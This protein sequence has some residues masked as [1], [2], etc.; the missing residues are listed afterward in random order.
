M[1]K[2]DKLRQLQRDGVIRETVPSLQ[3]WHYEVVKPESLPEEFKK[4]YET[5]QELRFDWFFMEGI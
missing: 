2:L 4:E 5:L 1:N 3:Y